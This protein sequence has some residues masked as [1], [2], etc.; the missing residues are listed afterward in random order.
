MIHCLYS[1]YMYFNLIYVILLI[2]ISV[3]PLGK[4]I[5]NFLHYLFQPSPLPEDIGNP[6]GCVRRTLELV[7][8]VMHSHNDHRSDSRVDC[9]E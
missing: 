5:A 2:S 3:Y 1:F 8:S 4:N 7:E 9:A 6:A